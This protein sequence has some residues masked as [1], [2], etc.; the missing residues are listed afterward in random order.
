[1]HPLLFEK[2]PELAEFKAK[3]RRY[4]EDEK[5]WLLDKQRDLLAQ[6]IP[7]HRKLAERGQVEL[8]TTP[9]YHPI[10]P[11]LFDKRLAREAMP[12]VEPAELPRR[13]PRGRRG[14]RPPRRREPPRALRRAPRGD[15]AER[16]LGLPGDDPAAGPARHRVDRHRRGDPR[17][18]DR[19]QGR[20]RRPGLRPPSRAALP[21]LEGR[22]GRRTSWRSSSA[23]TRCP[24]RSASTIS[25]APGPPP[26][27]TSSAS[28]TPSA[29][30]AGTNPATLVPVI[31]DGENCW[32]YYP[33]G[34]VSFL[35]SLYHGAV[36]D[37]QGPAGHGRRVPPRASRRPTPCPGSSR[38]AGSATTSPSGSATPRTTAAGTRCTR[39]AQFLV[40]RGASR[41]ARPGDPRPGLGRDLHRRGVRLVLVVRRRPLQRPR[42]ALRPPLPQAPAQRLH[43]ARRRTRPAPSSRRSRR[44]A[45]TGRSTT[46]RRAS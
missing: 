11:L 15:V 39:P 5:Q 19:R 37:P 27:P 35:R 42:R 32:E 45:A 21:A 6:I 7:L 16:G 20:A 1:M 44:P 41:A 34:G 13:L 10:L 43:A 26:R 38:G 22:R 2:D 33:D 40:Q 30:P 18:L 17:L 9:F 46:S 23:T 8:T 25:A 28:S 24:T 36:R 3:G 12:D 31:L 4:T 14:P 29:T